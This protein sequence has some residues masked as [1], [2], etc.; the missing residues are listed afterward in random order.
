MKKSVASIALMVLVYGVIFAS[1]VAHAQTS[2][3]NTAELSKTLSR[4]ANNPRYTGRVIGTHLR[5]SG[6]GYL[7]E[8]RILRPD[9]S[10]IVVLVSPQSG[11]VI[12]DS[13][14]KKQKP[15]RKQ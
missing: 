12:R 4:L 6:K 13:E 5:Q 10:I 2:K 3:K 14:R 15:N 7:Y 11:R 9:D 1:T 8:I